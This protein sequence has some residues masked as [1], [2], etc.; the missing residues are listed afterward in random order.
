MN[1]EYPLSTSGY[2]LKFFPSRKECTAVL[3]ANPE[4]SSVPLITWDSGPALLLLGVSL[5]SSGIL[6]NRG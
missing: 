2:D 1:Q 5:C 4:F 3:G 6:K